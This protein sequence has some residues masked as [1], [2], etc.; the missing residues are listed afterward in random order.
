MKCFPEDKHMF[1]IDA[2]P[3]DRTAAVMVD[4]ALRPA[5]AGAPHIFHV[6]NPRPATLDLATR[7]LRQMGYS[8]QERPYS[9]WRERLISCSGE[10]NALRCEHASTPYVRCL[11]PL[12]AD[13]VLNRLPRA[14]AQNADRW[15]NHSHQASWG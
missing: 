3:A 15:S 6:A 12:R 14:L 10:D 8:F 4:L 1:T 7:L 11:L 2:I 9:L 13:H 5:A